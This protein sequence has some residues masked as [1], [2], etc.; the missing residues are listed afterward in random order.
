MQRLFASILFSAAALFAS[1]QQHDI[2]VTDTDAMRASA[3]KHTAL[4]DKTVTLDADQKAKVQEIYMNL[5]RKLE[6]MNQRFEKGGL[7]KEEREAEMA[8]Q[9]VS[10]EKAVDQQLAE[11]LTPDQAGTWREAKK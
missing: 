5:E 2:T 1:A 6:G 10:L 8:P 9:W 11:V 4:V 7:T 3:D